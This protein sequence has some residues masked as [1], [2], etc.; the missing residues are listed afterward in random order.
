[1]NVIDLSPK[2]KLRENIEVMPLGDGRFILRD[3]VGY[4]DST[5]ILNELSVMILSFLDGKRTES[6]IKNLIKSV[7]GIDLPEDQLKKFIKTLDEHGFL[8]TQ[9]FRLM[10]ERVRSDYRN[11]NVRKSA[12]AGRSF[13][14]GG[15][16]AEEF[17]YSILSLFPSDFKVENLKAVLSPHIEISNGM[18]IYGMVWNIIKNS[19]K[20]PDVFVVLGTSHAYSPYTF[21]LTEKDFETPFGT[22]KNEKDTVKEIEK[23]LG[24]DIFEDEILHKNEHSIEFQAVF[25]KYIFPSSRIVPVLCSASRIFLGQTVFFDEAVLK[26]REALFSSLKG[27]NFVLISASDLAHIGVRFGDG[28]VDQYMIT[29]VRLKDIVSLWN[30]AQNSAKGFLDSVMEDGNAR[31]VCGLAPTYALLKITEN[32]EAKGNIIG[33]DIWVDETASAV[34]FGGAFLS[35]QKFL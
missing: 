17:F 3:V 10:R 31:R 1:M 16:E 20:N 4:S 30:F 34:S 26:L 14:S 27:A 11:Q 25:I 29:L 21:I 23:A 15:K 5:L 19:L 35:A 22:L 28:P 32:T 18:K 7:Y 24:K 8:D 6:E 33:W 2:P 9:N 13:P 12:L